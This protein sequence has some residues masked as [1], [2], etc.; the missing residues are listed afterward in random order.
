M[1][2]QFIHNL[3][4]LRFRAMPLSYEFAIAIF[5]EGKSP[6]WGFRGKIHS[7]EEPIFPLT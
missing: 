5:V 4:T 3:T 7:D 6:F 2:S 1:N